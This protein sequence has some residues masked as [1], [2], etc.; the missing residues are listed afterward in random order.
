MIHF[1]FLEP[2]TMEDPDVGEVFS[3]L[4]TAIRV[5]DG[6]KQIG[7]LTPTEYTAME[8]KVLADARKWLGLPPLSE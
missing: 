6:L 1:K 3:K 7:V 8:Q 5:L 2:L 4:M